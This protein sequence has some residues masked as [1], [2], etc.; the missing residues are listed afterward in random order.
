M[1]PVLIYGMRTAGTFHS[2]AARILRQHIDQLPGCGRDRSFTISDQ[3]DCKALLRTFLKETSV[4]VEVRQYASVGWSLPGSRASL[5]PR[6]LT[7]PVPVIAGHQHAWSRPTAER[8]YS[9]WQ[10]VGAC[11]ARLPGF[12]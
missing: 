8:G 1:L 3:T 11:C 7:R 4:K 9:G 5:G 10:T 2:I 6:G 12:A